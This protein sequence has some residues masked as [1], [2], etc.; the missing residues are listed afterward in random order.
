MVG[1]QAGKPVS[2]CGELAGDP[3]LAPLLI[4][5]G[6]TR[7]SMIPSSIPQVKEVIL[8]TTYEAARKLAEEVLRN[9]YVEQIRRIIDLYH[10]KTQQNL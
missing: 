5:F 8:N 10:Q 1:E 9:P 4:G 2:I 6:I 3:F 7:L